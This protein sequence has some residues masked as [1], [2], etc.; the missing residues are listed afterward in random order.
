[1]KNKYLTFGF[2]RLFI[3]LL[4]LIIIFPTFLFA[5]C[6]KKTRTMN[7]NLFDIKSQTFKQIN[8]EKYL[9]G[10]VAGEINNDAPIEALKAQAVL[11]RTFTLKFIKDDKSKYEG[12]DISTDITESQAYNPDNIND[13]I[14]QAVAETKDLTVFYNDEYINA[15]FHSNSGGY[16]SFAKNGLN[17]SGDEPPYIKS[18][19]TN[20]T[21]NNT[22]N[23]KWYYT[24][25]KDDILTTLRNMKI[26][27]SSISTF[28]IGQKDNSGRSKTFI[29]GGKEISANNFRL[30]IGST[31]MKSTL[32]TNIIINENSIYFEGQGYGHGVGLSQEYAIVLANEGKNYKEIISYFFKDIEI[33]SYKQ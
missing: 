9:E 19:K 1:M 32:I 16:T 29:I 7:I 27:I 2:N 5:S 3:F 30:N 8:L 10:V 12:A 21:S 26:N 11:A 20:E 14:R 17:F 31:K 25:T 23:Y 4:L 28:K 24:F 22:K 6:Q 15:W 33:K 18:I 13:N